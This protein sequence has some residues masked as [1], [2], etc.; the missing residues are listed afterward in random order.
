MTIGT[1][2]GYLYTFDISNNNSI[3]NIYQYN[4]FGDFKYAIE[5]A[6]DILAIASSDL[7]IYY[8][9]LTS[10]SVNLGFD[11]LHTSFIFSMIMP[12]SNILLTASYDLKAFVWNLSSTPTRTLV[13]A[14]HTYL[15]VEIIQ[16]VGYGDNLVGTASYEK[17]L[18]W[19]WVNGSIA[20]KFDMT[21]GIG[22]L[23]QVSSDIIAVGET[24]QIQIYSLRNQ[25]KLMTIAY[26]GLVNN[27]VAYSSDMLVATDVLGSVKLWCWKNGSLVS[28]FTYNPVTTIVNDMRL[29]D[30]D[31]LLVA[32]TLAF[33]YY[34]LKDNTFSKEFEQSILWEPQTVAAV[35]NTYSSNDLTDFDYFKLCV[36]I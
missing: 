12:S 27:M 8:Y 6:P 5:R 13:F 3:E 1:Q 7:K 17:V 10:F 34:S 14:Q 25:S 2:G 26:S 35:S 29:I 28:S 11:S 33:E 23:T 18:I 22:S 32:N 24:L 16:I 36:Y 9:D 20:M 31:I 4:G 21:T 30:Q 19:N 15:I